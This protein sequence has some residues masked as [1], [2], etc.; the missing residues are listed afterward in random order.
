MCEAP[1]I[2]ASS[3]VF[4]CRP[5]SRRVIMTEA[6]SQSRIK[7]VLRKWQNA[8]ETTMPLHYRKEDLLKSRIDDSA[9]HLVRPWNYVDFLR[10]LRSFRSAHWFAKYNI[11]S[12][13]ECARYGWT[14]TANDTLTCLSCHAKILHDPVTDPTGIVLHS[15]LAALHEQSCGWIN[16]VCPTSFKQ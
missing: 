3:F 5:L 15:Q 12:P 11:I 1:E 8:L 7:S 10:R 2:I 6:T 16:N 14:N 13:L 9:E 4:I